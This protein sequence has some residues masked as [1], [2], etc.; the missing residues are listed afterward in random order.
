MRKSSSIILYMLIISWWQAIA[1]KRLV[2]SMIIW[3]NNL[4]WKILVKPRGSKGWVPQETTKGVNCSC[5][6]LVTW[7]TWWNGLECKILKLS[8]LI[9]IIML[10]FRV[11]VFLKLKKIIR[12]WRV[13][14][15]KV[16]L[17]V[18][19]MVRFVVDQNYHMQLV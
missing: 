14:H 1:R 6:N 9:W 8:T 5:L 18:S 12:W 7:K 11:S 4:R 19:F 3:M 15:L 16:S 2:S 17:E 10:S 13:V